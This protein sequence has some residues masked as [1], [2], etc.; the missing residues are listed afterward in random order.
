M[1]LALEREAVMRSQYLIAAHQGEITAH[2]RVHFF[3]PFRVIH[4]DQSLGESVWRRNKAKALLKWFL[5]HPGKL[6]SVEQLIKLLWPD[7]KQAAAARNLHVTIHYLRHLL[8]PDLAPHQG[9]RFILRNKNNFYWFALDETW[10]TDVFDIQ[11]L[12][13][14]AK[15]ADQ[16]G[17]QTLAIFYYRQII[18]YCSLG[19]LPE[20]TYED[21]F[22]PYH[23]Q[24]D[25]AYTQVLERLLHLYSQANML[26]EVLT[27]AFQALS[28]NPYS[29]TAVKAI[30]IAYF[31]QGNIAGAIRQLDDFQSFLKQELGIEP[32]EDIL[33]LRGKM[34]ARR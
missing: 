8:E 6:H 22:Y 26:D 19:F 32:G 33:L 27:I 3:G 17:D 14:L 34:L 16:G 10:W 4:D 20:D 15:K 5:L 2:Y 28:L 1:S 18:R 29:E 25:Y 21:I 24:Y 11:R 30:I 7:L 23:R 12:S 31:R 13:L 9:S